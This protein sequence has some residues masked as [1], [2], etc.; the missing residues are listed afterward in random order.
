MCEP[1]A[2]R[3]GPYSSEHNVNRANRINPR[4]ATN[5]T[6]VMVL[7]FGVAPFFGPIFLKATVARIFIMHSFG[8]RP[9]QD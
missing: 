8:V 6:C 2:V 5:G 1:P 3:E 7:I 4:H 9:P